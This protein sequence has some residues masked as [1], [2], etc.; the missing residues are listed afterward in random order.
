MITLILRLRVETDE[1][2]YEEYLPDKAIRDGI[3]GIIHV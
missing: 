1:W 2:T 3:G